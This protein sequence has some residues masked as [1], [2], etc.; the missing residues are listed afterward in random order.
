[1]RGIGS[2]RGHVS[3][4]VSRV[5]L[6]DPEALAERLL[7]GGLCGAAAMCRRVAVLVLIN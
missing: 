2:D 1:M 6:T 4:H 5:K 3:P 7:F